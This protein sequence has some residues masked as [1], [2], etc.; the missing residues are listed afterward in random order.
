MARISAGF[1]APL[2]HRDR[3]GLGYLFIKVSLACRCFCVVFDNIAFC[4]VFFGFT[5]MTWLEYLPAKYRVFSMGY[6]I[7]GCTG[8][9]FSYLLYLF[10]FFH[11]T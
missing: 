2:G 5:G 11:E 10:I 1:G 3:F 8:C 4:V 7:A 9:H 6:L